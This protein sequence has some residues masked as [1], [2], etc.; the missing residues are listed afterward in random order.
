M[1]ISGGLP[2]TEISWFSTDNRTIETA[3]SDGER[4]EQDIYCV[5][6][7]LFYWRS[8]YGNSLL[9]WRHE[10]LRRCCCH[11]TVFYALYSLQPVHGGLRVAVFI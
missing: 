11:R 6:D 2:F 3:V 4:H 9:A 8:W 7:Y 5:D 10:E 1:T